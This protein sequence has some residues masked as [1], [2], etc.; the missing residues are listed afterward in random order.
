MTTRCQWP[1][2]DCE[3]TANPQCGQPAA[4]WVNYGDICA[5]CS[6]IGCV[7]AS[8][9]IAHTAQERREWRH[10]IKHITTIE[11]HP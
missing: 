1:A 9:C 5:I 4:Y 11:D 10:W 7:G 8:L 2:V 3:G 6:G